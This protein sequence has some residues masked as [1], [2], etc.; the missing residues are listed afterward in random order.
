MKQ[1]LGKLIDKD[2]LERR[3][4]WLCMMWPRVELLREL[5]AS[6][7]ILFVISMTTK[8]QLVASC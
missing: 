4:K 6:R 3:D 1:W 8:W 5:L 2:D 7:G